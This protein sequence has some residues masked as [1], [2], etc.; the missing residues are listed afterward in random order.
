MAN[1]HTPVSH[2]TK[3]CL[4]QEFGMMIFSNE[5]HKYTSTN[6]YFFGHY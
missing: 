5:I 3:M 2:Y 4:E 1:Q 6:Y